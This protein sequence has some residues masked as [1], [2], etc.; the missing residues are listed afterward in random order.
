MLKKSASGVHA[1]LSDSTYRNVRLR[2]FARCDLAGQPFWAS[3]SY[4]AL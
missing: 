1:S 4:L 3:W 2:R